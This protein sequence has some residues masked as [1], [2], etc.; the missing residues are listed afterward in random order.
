MKR[1]GLHA[2]VIVWM[3]LSMTIVVYDVA[4]VLLRPLSMPG[5][6]LA[7]LWGMY[8]QY[9]SVD[10]TYGDLDNPFVPAQALMSIMEIML[11]VAGLIMSSKGRTTL[12]L[13]LVFTSV[14]L[15][16]AKTMLI[17]MIELVGGFSQTAHSGWFDVLTIFILPNMVWVICP[18]LVA[19]STGRRL[20]QHSA[21]NQEKGMTAAKTAV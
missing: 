12:A 7:F 10:R 19:L 13:I 15:T 2:W 8:E 17:L 4:F 14:S 3:C 20:L 16:G 1:E 5:G 6:E 9:I 11:G 18:I 21:E